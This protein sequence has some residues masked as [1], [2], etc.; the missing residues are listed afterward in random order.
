VT[1]RWVAVS[2]LAATLLVALLVVVLPLVSA[3]D[4]AL[5]RYRLRQQ[6]LISLR[7]A[8]SDGR[9]IAAPAPDSGALMLPIGSD[10]AAIAALQERL[11]QLLGA[12]GAQASSVEALPALPLAGTRQIGVRAQFAADTP[13]LAAILHG[14]EDAR[15]LLIVTALNV[16]AR[17]SRAVG[18]P[19]PLDVEIELYG[20]KP[21]A[22]R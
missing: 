3:Y 11:A 8:A 19:N 12:A 17:S 15:P 21:E 22:G 20:F 13:G 4:E 9:A 18:T 14:I 6:L 10:S 7:A 16:R 2:W 5:G 1:S